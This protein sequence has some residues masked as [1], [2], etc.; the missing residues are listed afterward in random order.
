MGASQP[1]STGGSSAARAIRAQAASEPARLPALVR[2][3]I[4]LTMLSFRQL[5]WS[6][7]TLMVLFPLAGCTLFLLRRRY[8]Q[9]E[10][11][12]RAINAFSHE[13]VILI[14]AAFV[15]PI[16]ALAYATTSIGGDRENRTLLFLLVRPIPRSLVFLAKLTATLPLVL[17][18]VMG[19]FYLYCRLAG[20]AGRLAFDLYLPAI[21]YMT[22][23]Y[24][25]LFH[26]FAVTFRHSTIAALTYALFMEF[27]LGNM[28]GIIKRLAVNYYGR[29]IMFNLGLEE[30]VDLPDPQWFEPVSVSTG[31]DALL[32]IAAGGIVIALA[33]FQW[34]EYHD[35]T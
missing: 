21:F 24:I 15:V 25:S 33:I 6:S 13:F 1:V 7:N 2:A 26:L 20:P 14:F 19:S 12:P 32:W 11:L 5:L 3:W 8:D 34:R 27:F 23:A 18:L 10:Y 17:G 35:L 29:S 9:I 22:I 31:A 16:C 4:T 28:P 30:G